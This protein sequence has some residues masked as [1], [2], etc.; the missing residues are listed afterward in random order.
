MLQRGANVRAVINKIRRD[1]VLYQPA[2]APTWESATSR[3]DG[4]NT[5]TTRSQES[6][7]SLGD[8][9]AYITGELTRRGAA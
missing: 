6:Q 8:T 2:P 3:V 7:P 5:D 1:R 4:W 9:L